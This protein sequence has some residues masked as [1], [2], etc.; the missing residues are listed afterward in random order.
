MSQFNPKITIELEIESDLQRVSKS[1]FF[2]FK[3]SVQN[4]VKKMAEEFTEDQRKKNKH[5][6]ET[7]TVEVTDNEHAQP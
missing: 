3:C 6:Y 4:T 7:I 1:D 2:S 5:L